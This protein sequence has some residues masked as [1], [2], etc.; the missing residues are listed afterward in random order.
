M[1]GVGK[2][3]HVSNFDWQLEVVD[4]FNKAVRIFKFGNLNVQS[5]YP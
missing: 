4:F 1:V 3:T 5:E 2:F